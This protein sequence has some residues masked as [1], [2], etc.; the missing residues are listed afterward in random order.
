LPS[1]LRWA[2]G[3]EGRAA[4]EILSAFAISAFQFSAFQLLKTAPAP[5]AAEA[6]QEQYETFFEQFN[7]MYK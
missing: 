3:A 7:Q 5:L 4:P 6:G 1:W 2:D